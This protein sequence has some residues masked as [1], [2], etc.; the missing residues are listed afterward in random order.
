[1]G[2]VKQKLQSF[3]GGRQMIKD[4]LFLVAFMIKAVK[5]EV[6]T[7][8]EQKE[9]VNMLKILLNNYLKISES[10]KAFILNDYFLSL[11]VKFL[12]RSISSF[13]FLNERIKA[14]I[15]IVATVAVALQ[16]GK[17]TEKEMEDII[18]T[19]RDSLIKILKNEE[20]VKLLLS[21]EVINFFIAIV[22]QFL[23]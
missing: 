4:I 15:F 22:K 8:E 11:L 9:I 16:D 2:L 14:V 23:K 5:D 21:R 10:V 12:S 6:I 1:M 17:I 13:T 3:E 7:D 20:I 18:N 19:A